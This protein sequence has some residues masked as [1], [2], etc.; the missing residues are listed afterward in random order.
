MSSLNAE[1]HKILETSGSK[2][3]LE[4]ILATVAVETELV[5]FMHRYTVFNGNFAGG[6]ASLAGAFHIRQDLFRDPAVMPRHCSDRS[7]DIASYIYFAAEDEYADRFTGSRITHRGLAQ[8]LLSETIS[9]CKVDPD[10]FD[11][12]FR[13]HDRFDG[14]LAEVVKGYRINSVQSEDD[15]FDALGFHIGSELLADQEFNIIDTFLTRN[16]PSLVRH[17]KATKTIHGP[18]AY[19]WISLHTAVEVE[20]FQN[21]ITAAEKAIT[22]YCGTEH[23]QPDVRQLIVG[24][25]RKFSDFQHRFFHDIMAA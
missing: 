17:L 11:A 12:T 18:E 10:A 23:T 6:V 16:Y 19:R 3:F 14:F 25:F 8:A 9:F 1:I 5:R 2:R 21:A 15:L 20:H 24:G 7:A 13:L 22:Y 4:A